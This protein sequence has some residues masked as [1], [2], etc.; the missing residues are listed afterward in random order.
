M[1]NPQTTSLIFGAAI[2]SFG[3]LMAIGMHIV[4]SRE[5][6]ESK[7]RVKA[8]LRADQATVDA[9]IKG[10]SDQEKVQWAKDNDVRPG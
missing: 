9:A 2:A 7:E 1:D 10:V 4:I 8:A 3:I 6:S 5:I